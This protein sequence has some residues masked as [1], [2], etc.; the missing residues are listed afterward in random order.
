MTK[1]EMIRS[2]VKDNLSLTNEQIKQQV[3]A[4]YGTT[5]ETNLIISIVGSEKD[6]RVLANTEGHVR[7]KAKELL[8]CCDNDYHHARNVLQIVRDELC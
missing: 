8:N 3:R 6:R 5:V 4:K 2:I 7:K 1:S